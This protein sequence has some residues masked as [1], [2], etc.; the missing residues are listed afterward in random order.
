MAKAHTIDDVVQSVINN[1]QTLLR[2]AV[3]HVAEQ[4]EDD[5]KNKAVNV[6]YKYYYGGYEPTSYDRI[7]ALEH[8]IVPFSKISVVG[9]KLKCVVGVEYSPSALEEYLDALGGSPYKASKE[10]G[11]ADAEWVVQNFWEGKHPYTNG[12]TDSK[13]AKESFDYHYSS[14]TQDEMMRKN[15][16]TGDG[17][18]YYAHTIFPH[19]VMN[20]M[21]VNGSKLF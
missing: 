3:V 18:L 13:S 10:Y 12:S 19:A 6:L 1:Y 5:I 4:A 11:R 17:L 7:Y 14:A 20:H 9:Q 2:D 16:Q 15:D 8:S 21:M